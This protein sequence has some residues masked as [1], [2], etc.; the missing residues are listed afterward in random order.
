MDITERTDGS[1]M[2]SLLSGSFGIVVAAV[3]VSAWAITGLTGQLIA[4]IG[5]AA[6]APAWY[7]RPLSFTASL[8]NELRRRR[9]PMPKWIS[10]CALLGFALVSA[11]VALQWAT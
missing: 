1:R 9:A 10:A 8:S 4:G 6:L 3:C 11:G 7:L 2:A 5:F